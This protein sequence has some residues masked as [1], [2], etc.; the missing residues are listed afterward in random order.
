M[1]NDT[2]KDVLT[3]RGFLGVGSAALAAAGI[4]SGDKLAAQEQS[5]SKQKKDRSASDPG[6]TNPAIDAANPDSNL[7][8]PTDAGGVQTFKYPF[9]FAH[10]RM[11]E[12]GWSR[13]VTQRELPISKS[14]AGVDMRL[15][16]GGVR[17]LHWHT[18]AEWAFMTYGTARITCID[19]EGKSFVTDVK[20]NELW[21]FP[22]GIPHSI[23]GLAPDGCEFILVFDD[24][25]FSE[26]E[27]VLLTDLMAHTPP[28]VV[29][30]NFG[31]SQKAL[32]NM[33]KKE[34][35]IFQTD[36]PGPLAEDRRIA[37][38]ALGPSPIDF[39]F[40]TM[41]MPPTKSNKSGEVRIIDAKNFKITTTAAAIVTVKPGGVRELHWHPNADEWQYFYA[42]KGRM[43]VFATGGRAR[44]MDFETGDVGYI[45]KTLPHY[46]ENTGTTDLKFLEMFKSSYYQDLALSEWL[47][48]TPPEL[49]AA[50]LNLDKA[51]LDAI[52]REETVIMPE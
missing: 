3:R 1:S 38:G 4:F 7:A 40:R 9:S 6:P 17:E 50:H 51:T 11:Q 46:V 36:V 49:V 35:F 26:F 37:A 21:F 42:G 13:E 52:P 43:T 27:T 16:A 5:D 44:T 30:K 48:H 28:D 15:T 29:A 18:A 45:Q 25:N 39:A 34:K 41:D 14:M 31:V 22:P 24:G 12:G 32:A 8:L 2:E 23:Q 20:E 19:A 33:P 47:S 10:K